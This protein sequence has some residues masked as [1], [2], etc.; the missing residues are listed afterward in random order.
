M[1]CPSVPDIFGFYAIL[2]NPVVGYE[3][4]TRLLVTH[5]VPFVQLRMKDTDRDEVRD[6]AVMM[7]EVTRGSDSRFI[8]N[9]DPELA[10]EVGADGV[11]LGQG[12]MPYALAREIVGPDAVVGLSTHNVEQTRAACEL[13]PDYIGIGPV[14]PTTTKKIPDPPLGLDGMRDMLAAATVPAVAL[15]S[16]TTANLGDIVRAGAANFSLVRP[17]NGAEDPEPVLVAIL[18]AWRDAMGE[19]GSQA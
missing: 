19:A 7:R 9:D 8:V 5:Q 17:L 16:I 3:T 4:L 11:H 1:T 14:F 15:G 10:A 18:R 6:A 12:D 13:G 2:T